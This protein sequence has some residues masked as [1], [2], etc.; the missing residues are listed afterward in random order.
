MK[1]KKIGERKRV[2][3]KKID[4]E[5]NIVRKKEKEEEREEKKAERKN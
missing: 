4:N 1:M 3:K 5:V 2:K